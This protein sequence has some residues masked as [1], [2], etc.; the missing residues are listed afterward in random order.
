MSKM[1]WI[2]VLVAC[3]IGLAVLVGVLGT[4]NEPSTS[5]AEATS[6]LCTSL[7]ALDSSVKTLTGIDTSTA[8]KSEY[9]ADVTAVENAWTQVTTSAQAVQNAPTGSLDSAWDRLLGGC[10][11]RV[12]R[13]IG[14]RRRLIDQLVGPGPHLGCRVDRVAALRMHARLVHQHDDDNVELDDDDN[15]VGTKPVAAIPRGSRP[16]LGVVV[17]KKPVTFPH[18]CEEGLGSYLRALRFTPIGR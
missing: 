8:T 9:Q 16:P 3:G 11:E 12:E 10:Q 5:K 13:L 2:I 14:Q 1:T 15:V 4:R 18:N 7:K 6:T 17:P